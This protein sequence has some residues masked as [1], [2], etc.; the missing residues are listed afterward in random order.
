M[1]IFDHV[2]E[3]SS[4]FNPWAC[5]VFLRKE[6]HGCAAVFQLCHY[7]DGVSVQHI[8][9]GGFH[10]PRAAGSGPVPPPFQDEQHAPQ[11]SQQRSIFLCGD[12]LAG[13]IS[14]GAGG[15]GILFPV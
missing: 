4:I 7:A 15:I 6:P 1:D 2:F 5:G 9:F 13:R 12:L 11:H 8:F 10:A 3:W 14:G